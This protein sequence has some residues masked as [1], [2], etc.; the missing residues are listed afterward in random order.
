MPLSE[1]E[2]LRSEPGEAE[3]AGGKKTNGSGVLVAFLI[4]LITTSPFFFVF[5]AVLEK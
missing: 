4:F 3:G 5:K 1:D 2:A